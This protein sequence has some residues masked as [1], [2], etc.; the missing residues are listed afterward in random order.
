MSL[1]LI[2]GKY[3]LGLHNGPLTDA[4][5]RGLFW[6]SAPANSS[7][8]GRADVTTFNPPVWQNT[9]QEHAFDLTGAPIPQIPEPRSLALVA[10]GCVVVLFPKAVF[11]NGLARS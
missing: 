11:P 2:A 7:A 6:E 3:W 8:P 4:T 9:G 1:D 10:F 5:F